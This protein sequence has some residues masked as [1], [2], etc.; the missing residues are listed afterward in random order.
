MITAVFFDWGGVC[1]VGPVLGSVAAHFA[2]HL[3]LSKRRIEQALE[4]RNHDY[5]TGEITAH[6]YWVAFA[7]ALGIP[8]DES[9]FHKIFVTTPVVNPDVF[10]FIAQ[11]RK[12]YR[13]G[14]ISDNYREM[15]AACIVKYQLRK[16]F[17]TLTF[18][19]DVHVKKPDP[20]IYLLA[21]K[22]LRVRP[23][24]A[25]FLDDKQKNALGARRVGM[26]AIVFKSIPQARRELARL[27][28]RIPERL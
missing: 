27:G 26:K 12:Q 10:R 5:L 4:L 8:L 13:V 19:N 2:H 3:N 20:K 25:V 24:D 11:V 14:L 28:V 7:S 17:D 21:C 16:R 23:E 15:V 6:E 18:S 9:W 1:T 22:K